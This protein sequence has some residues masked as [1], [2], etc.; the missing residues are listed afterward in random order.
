MMQKKQE[1]ACGENRCHITMHPI[2]QDCEQ[3]PRRRTPIVFVDETY[4]HGSHSVPK[5]WQDRTTGLLVSFG[6]GD[7]FIIL[8]AGDKNGFAPGSLLVF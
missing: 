6:K 8:H 2:F 7:R 4:I 1:A 3:V 5:C